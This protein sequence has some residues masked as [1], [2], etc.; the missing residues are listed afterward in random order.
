M[1]LAI[2]ARFDNVTTSK[3]AYLYRD[4]AGGVEE[5]W[6]GRTVAERVRAIETR[7][8]AAGALAA[9]GLRVTAIRGA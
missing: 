3:G 6:R 2:A 5:S 9:I 1:L 4:V 7:R 8:V